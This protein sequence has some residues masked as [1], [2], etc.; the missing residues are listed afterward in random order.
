MSQFSRENPS[1][2]FQQLGELYRQVHASGLAK[3]A[4]PAKVFSGRSLLQHIG[5]VRELVQYTGARSIL[6]YGCGKAL[7]YREKNLKLPEGVTIPS[8]QEFWGVEDIRFYDPGVEEFATR[9]QGEFD[10]VVST[11]VLEHIPEEDLDWVLGECFTYARGF[12]YMNIASYPA[13]KILPNGWNA[14]V[15]I[16][17]PEWWRACI[18]RAANGWKGR[19]YVFDVTEKRTGFAGSLIRAFTGSKLKLTRIERWG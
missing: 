18:E 6:D 1:P 5:I 4:A 10:G 13:K 16:Q 14:H 9:P 11:D 3:G 2:R 15:T 8:V 19:A 12:L 7:L 17:P